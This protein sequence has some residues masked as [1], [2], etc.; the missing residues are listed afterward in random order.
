MMDKNITTFMSYN[1]AGLDTVKTKWIRDFIDVTNADFISIQEHFKKTKNIEEY[2]AHE[3]SSHS[4]FI[5]PGHREPGTDSGRPKGGLAML[6]SKQ[7][8]VRKI[9]VKTLNFRL[10]AQVLTFP[11]TR[12]LWINTY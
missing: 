7:N 6:S 11:N 10:Q 9:R 5:V 12:L 3:F 2:F 1:S 4:A 8:K